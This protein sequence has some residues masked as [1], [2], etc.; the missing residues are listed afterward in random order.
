MLH[1]SS[2]ITHLNTNISNYDTNGLIFAFTDQNMK[3]PKALGVAYNDGRVLD[4]QINASSWL[5]EN[6]TPQ[7]GRLLNPI[8]AWCAQKSDPHPTFRVSFDGPTVVLGMVIQSDSS[9]DNFVKQVQLL[10]QTQQGG[11]FENVGVK[12]MV[13][14]PWVFRRLV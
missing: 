11:N 8:S 4:R 1:L 7:H 12:H 6:F 10:V 5:N 3:C 2:Y 14:S 9:A 13:S